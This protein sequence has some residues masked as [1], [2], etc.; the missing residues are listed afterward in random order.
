MIVPGL[1]CA[2]SGAITRSTAVFSS[3]TLPEVS[4]TL[5]ITMVFAWVNSSSAEY[6]DQAAAEL[7]P[8]TGL[9]GDNS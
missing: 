5:L 8:P 7:T 4:L 6:N 1:Y 2:W 9:E 3:E